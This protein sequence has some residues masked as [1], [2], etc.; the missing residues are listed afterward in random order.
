MGV[1]EVTSDWL[2][3]AGVRDFATLMGASEKVTSEA[4]GRE[5]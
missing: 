1:S 5:G 4:K 2:N 3:G